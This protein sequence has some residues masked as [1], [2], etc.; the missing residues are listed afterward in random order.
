MKR[1]QLDWRNATVQPCKNGGHGGHDVEVPKVGEVG[2]RT[3]RVYPPR[4]EDGGRYIRGP[5]VF[6]VTKT[7]QVREID[8]YGEIGVAA[9]LQVHRYQGVKP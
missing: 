8:P 2:V 1:V 3:Y 7:G 5:L 6:V 9:R 4:N